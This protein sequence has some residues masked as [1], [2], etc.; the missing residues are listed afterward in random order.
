[1]CCIGVLRLRRVF[2]GFVSE[3]FQVQLDG[4]FTVET[5]LKADA[6][7]QV[8]RSKNSGEELSKEVVLV[9]YE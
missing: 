6:K 3:L 9:M 1:M 2:S 4:S 8:R 7:S 5:N